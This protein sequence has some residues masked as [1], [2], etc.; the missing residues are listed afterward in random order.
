MDGSLL[1]PASL[2]V[3]LPIY[4]SQDSPPSIRSVRTVKHAIGPRR[5]NETQQNMASDRHLIAHPVKSAFIER[6]WR[7]IRP[8]TRHTVL[9]HSAANRLSKRRDGGGGIG[10]KALRFSHSEWRVGMASGLDHA[11]HPTPHLG[12]RDC[13]RHAHIKYGSRSRE[14]AASCE[15]VCLEGRAEKYTVH[16]G[17]HL[18]R[19]RLLNCSGTDR[20]EPLTISSTSS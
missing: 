13:T 20:T 15:S 1:N 16:C 3:P 18:P 7:A 14:A 12:R 10:R 2:N 6:L 4:C 5:A 19:S 11:R 8:P 9:Q 17:V